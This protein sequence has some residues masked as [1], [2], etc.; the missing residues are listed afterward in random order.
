[1]LVSTDL[2]SEELVLSSKMEGNVKMRT[3]RSHILIY[4]T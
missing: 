4:E 1:M 3:E 2:S